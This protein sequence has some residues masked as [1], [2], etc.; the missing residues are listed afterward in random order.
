M[1][2]RVRKLLIPILKLPFVV[3][4]YILGIIRKQVLGGRVLVKRN[5]VYYIPMWI[6][7]AVAIALFI[8]AVWDNVTYVA[9]RVYTRLSSVVIQQISYPPTGEI[10]P[11]FAPSVQHWA[12]QI[13]EW[14]TL[15]DVDTQLMATVMQI[16]SCGHPTVVSSAG[17]RGLFQVMPF[18]FEDNENMVDPDTNAKRSGL[19]LNYCYNAAGGDVGLAL[20]CYNGGPSVINR[21]LNSWANETKRYYRWGVGI[22]SDAIVNLSESD[23]LN[24]WM[25]AGGSRLCSSALN[26]VS[27]Y[28]SHVPS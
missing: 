22:Y 10:A 25:S 13:D 9:Q 16:E 5:E 23:T 26:E 14:S 19:F 4:G 11:F 15:Y 28:S 2:Q 24:Q 6:P 1:A 7:I 18:H 3:L 27:N 12:G 20:A 21:P 17:A 8:P